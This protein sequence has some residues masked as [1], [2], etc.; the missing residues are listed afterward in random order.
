MRMTKAAKIVWFIVC[1]LFVGMIST[2]AFRQARQREIQSAT[3]PHSFKRIKPQNGKV[4]M[5]PAKRR[6]LMP[7]ISLDGATILGVGSEFAASDRHYYVVYTI[8]RIDEDGVVIYF[9]ADG[10]EPSAVRPSHGTVKLNWK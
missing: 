7:T 3:L 5:E 8:K 1:L 2:Y 4:L 6:G 9:Q 10:S